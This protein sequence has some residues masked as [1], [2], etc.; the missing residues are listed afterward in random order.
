MQNT[1]RTYIVVYY[2]INYLKALTFLC[3]TSYGET[4]ITQG[5]RQSA[6]YSEQR[7]KSKQYLYEV[8]FQSF[9]TSKWY[10]NNILILYLSDNIL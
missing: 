2:V 10:P 7:T 4:F 9:V 6:Y 5:R 3:Y 8:S 1:L